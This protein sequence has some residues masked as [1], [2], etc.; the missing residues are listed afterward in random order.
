MVYWPVGRRASGRTVAA[1][2]AVARETVA[3]Q[4]SGAPSALALV[5]RGA[6]RKTRGERRVVRLSRE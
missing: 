4:R 6:E 3:A 5:V 1:L 2:S